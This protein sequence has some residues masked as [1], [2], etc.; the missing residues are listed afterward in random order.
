MTAAKEIP[1]GWSR[2]RLR[3]DAYLNPLKSRLDLSGNTE[4][5]FIPMDAVGELGGLALNETRAYRR[6]LQWVHV[7]RG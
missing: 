2:R 7:F 5:S 1:A 6:G 3:F 4:V